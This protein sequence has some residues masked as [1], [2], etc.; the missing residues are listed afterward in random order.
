MF[1]PSKHASHRPSLR[2]CPS[3]SGLVVA[4]IAL[5]GAG[6]VD[7]SSPSSPE[8]IDFQC[9]IPENE[10]VATGSGR[11]GLPSL[12]NPEI[13]GVNHSGANYL[14]D[15]DRVIALDLDGTRLAV[16]LNILWYHEVV[17]LEPG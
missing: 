6:C 4:L 2:R 5:T 1:G 13:V 12:Q 11:D 7:L 15:E 14:A 3:G 9:Q 8:Q 16:P 10:V 17:N